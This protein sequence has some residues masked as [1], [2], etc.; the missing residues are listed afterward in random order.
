LTLAVETA[1][2]GTS[3]DWRLPWLLVREGW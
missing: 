2:K 1:C 3:S